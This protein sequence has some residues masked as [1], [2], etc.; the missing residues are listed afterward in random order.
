MAADVTLE[1]NPVGRGDRSSFLERFRPLSSR[2]VMP[3]HAARGCALIRDP[4]GD[5]RDRTI[6]R[7]SLQ[8]AVAVMRD[9]FR[10]P[11]VKIAQMSLDRELRILAEQDFGG[12]LGFFRA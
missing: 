3:Q 4:L 5:Q 12:S 9:V 7:P 10:P 1:L 11:P 6:W 8:Q 2:E